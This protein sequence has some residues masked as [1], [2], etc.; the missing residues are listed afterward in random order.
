MEEKKICSCCGA[1]LREDSI[2]CFSCGTKVVCE[3][4]EAGV[5]RSCGAELPP[6]AA[7]CGFCGTKVFEA[8]QIEERTERG[9]GSNP[10]SGAYV[11]KLIKKS[12]ILLTS[13]LL[14]IFSFLPLISLKAETDAFDKEDIEVSVDFGTIDS[15]IFFFDSTKNLEDEDIVDS[16]LYEKIEELGEEVDEYS[17]KRKLSNVFSEV[18]YYF[19]RLLLQ[20]VLT[21]FSVMYLVSAVLSLLYI[22][23]T[24]SFFAFS[25]ADI[26]FFLFGKEKDFLARVSVC[27]LSF[28][29]VFAVVVYAATKFSYFGL[30]SSI[31][32]MDSPLEVSPSATLVLT[33][34]FAL[35]AL[36][37]ISVERIFFS[38]TI[39]VSVGEIIKRTLSSTAAT[40]VLFSVFLPLISFEAKTHFDSSDKRQSAS[41]A[42]DASYFRNLELTEDTREEIENT[43][44]HAAYNSIQSMC[45]RI[46]YYTKKEFTNG[47]ATSIISSIITSSFVGFGAVSVSGL[48]ALIPLIS[49]VTAL[50]A[51]LVL[52]QNILAISVGKSPKGWITIPARIFAF[53]LAIVVL[54][55]LIVFI[56]VCNHNISEVLEYLRYSDSSFKVLISSGSVVS[57]IFSVFMLS[58]PMKK[59]Q[60]R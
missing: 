44:E 4:R 15:F 23:L 3:E 1:E 32:N 60:E 52:W 49:V 7:F 40:V 18:A 35:I 39:K 37:A 2:F 31:P 38:G 34:V 33:I 41:L 43:D 20:S 27:L 47:Y 29:P 8:E 13:L 10:L 36:A 12:V 9:N 50:L 48:F 24:S 30:P 25:L 55:M 14:L 59:R 11:K 22:L 6:K 54:A 56:T 57:L 5:C 17:S 51:G 16:S 58:V 45:N 46:S 28:V 26:L 53:L 19:S 21:P 42:F